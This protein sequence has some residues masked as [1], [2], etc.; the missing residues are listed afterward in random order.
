MRASGLA[1]GQNGREKTF[2]AFGIEVGCWHGSSIVV[3]DDDDDADEI[4][5]RRGGEMGA[6]G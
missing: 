2:P 5:R 3:D 1:L 4:L 6:V